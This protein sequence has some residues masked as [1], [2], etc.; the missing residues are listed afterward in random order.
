MNRSLVEDNT[1][2]IFNPKLAKL[3]GMNEAI[4]LS[5]INYWLEKSTNL[6]EG[7]RWVYNTYENWQEQIY[8]LSVSSIRKAIKNLESMGIVISGNFNKCKMDKTK[9]YT[10]DFALIQQLYHKAYGN[11][12]NSSVTKEQKDCLNLVQEELSSN[13]AIPEITTDSIEE[14]EEG[15]KQPEKVRPRGE[16]ENRILCEGRKENSEAFKKVVDYYSANIRFPGS[17]DLEKIQFLCD[18]FKNPELIILAIKESVESNVRNLRYVEK[19]L[20]NWQDKGVKT[21]REA[22]LVI[23]NYK[24]RKGDKKNEG[25]KG[26]NGENRGGNSKSPKTNKGKWTGYKPPEPRILSDTNEDELI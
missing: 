4:I 5:Q 17:Y 7:R 8:V 2:I 25:L 16:D 10:I 21:L 9:W 6:I 13:K 14:E 11:C 22:E 20:Y 1:V 23:N 26:I 18:E 15:V 24:K 19:I 3:I 12:N